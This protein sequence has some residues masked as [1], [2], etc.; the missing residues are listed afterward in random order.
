MS[1]CIHGFIH[2]RHTPRLL[3]EAGVRVWSDVLDSTATGPQLLSAG[4]T[5][6]PINTPVDHDHISHGYLTY[7][8]GRPNKAMT[9]REWLQYL[10]ESANR[11]SETDRSVLAI[12]AHPACMYLLANFQTLK[13]FSIALK[14]YTSVFATECANH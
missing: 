9:A 8:P 14:K 5:S 4:L 12:L 10:K 6:L 11:L 13:K 1:W 2:D 7:Q 3:Y